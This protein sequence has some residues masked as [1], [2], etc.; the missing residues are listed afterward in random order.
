MKVNKGCNTI[1]SLLFIFSF[2][3]LLEDGEKGV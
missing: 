1:S 3:T 2:F